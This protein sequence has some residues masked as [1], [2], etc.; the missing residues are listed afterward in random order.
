METTHN[1][2]YNLIAF[3]RSNP[4]IA[5]SDLLNIELAVPQRMI[6]ND[7]WNKKFIIITAS[8]GVGKSFLLSAFA[9]LRAL[10][11]PATRIGLLA[12]SFRQC[13]VGSTYL[14]SGD[15]MCR[16][17]EFLEKPELLVSDVGSQECDNIFRNM[18][19]PVLTIGLNT[20]MK[21]G[22][23]LDHKIMVMDSRGFG[24]FRN[25]KDIV[26][27]DCVWIKAGSNAFGRE[28]DISQYKTDFVSN[29]NL[30]RESIPD[31][32][33]E[34]LAYFI[35]LVVGD[36]CLTQENY[37]IFCNTDNGLL[38]KYRGLCDKYFGR[39]SESKKEGDLR[40]I[41]V[42]SKLGYSFFRNIGLAGKYSEQKFI[43][44]II[45]RA[46]QDIQVAFLRGLFDTDGCVYFNKDV[47]HPYKVCVS[48]VS[49][50]LIHQVQLVLLNMGILSIRSTNRSISRKNLLYTLEISNKKS[51]LAFRN[52]I[53]FGCYYKQTK[54]DDVCAHISETDVERSNKDYIPSIGYC[55]E[56]I[57]RKI[58]THK[59]SPFEYLHLYSFFDSS[60]RFTGNIS[61]IT[62][63]YLEK[64]LTY[65]HSSN[66]E[67]DTIPYLRFLLSGNIFFGQVK[68][69]SQGFDYTYD[70]SVKDTHRYISNG[71]ISHNSKLMFEEVRKVWYASP[72]LREATV[73]K[74]TFQSDRCV[75]NF[76]PW[77]ATPPSLIEADPLGTGEKIRGARFHILLVDEFAQVPQEIFDAVIKPMAATSSSPMER[78][79]Y[80]QRIRKLQSLGV[81]TSEIES[82]SV[83]NK[84]IMA[85]SAFYKFNHMYTRIEQYN[86]IIEAGD[87]NYSVNS[88]CYLDMP[89]GFMND[90]IINEARETMASS[91]FRMEYLAEWESDSDGI[92]KASLLSKRIL[93]LGDSVKLTGDPNKEY[94]ISCDPAR[95]SDYFSIVVIELGNINKVVCASQ[96]HKMKFP[97]MAVTIMDYCDRFNVVRLV[98][99][100]Q[101]GGHAVKD[102]LADK[103]KFGS[104]V[105]LDMDDEE[106]AGVEGRKFLQMIK[107][108]P[109]YN[110]EANYATLALLEQEKLYFAGA[111]LFEE[112]IEEKERVYETIKALMSQMLNIVVTQT[113]SG[114]VHFDVPNG[115][116]HGA[117]KKDLYSALIYGAHKVYEMSKSDFEQE[118]VIWGSG[119]I[120][121]RGPITRETKQSFVV[122]TFAAL[123]K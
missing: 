104:K 37:I 30:R 79:K 62:R 8:R 25:L 67:D 88:L 92:F 16:A 108:S 70:F 72:I 28:V 86:R 12:P 26:V 115:G 20:G 22:G 93:P 116:G 46:P 10:L 85:S 89:D 24:E 13:V 91:I 32:I 101:G 68:S 44:N 4:I 63:G 39:F 35:G 7:M 76:R 118:R 122:P 80:I 74:P 78:V 51:I 5:L 84:I 112:Y 50:E 19:E 109:T 36:G 54:L 56:D 64:I 2:G 49:E 121:P 52:I 119:V 43:P 111:P 83:S 82:G 114:V 96:F 100:S 103:T 94:I 1:I 11:Y 34:N 110:A 38:D 18:P 69:I 77:Q 107:P 3:Y 31:I 113:K 9:C 45:L 53:G 90:D 105:I 66:I 47:S 6:F 21:L 55:L 57:V 61:S 87:T 33:D 17:G 81:D 65:C 23:A 59:G 14:L 27:G 99:D 41:S 95:T 117:Q 15:G 123:T 60:S 58:R 97:D 40:S 42:G 120:V 48:F 102:I 75:L 71:L 73:S 98:I 106:Y 29:G